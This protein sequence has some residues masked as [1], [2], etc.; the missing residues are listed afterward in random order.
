MWTLLNHVQRFIY[1]KFNPTATEQ[2][3]YDTQDTALHSMVLYSSLT[4]LPVSAT[5]YRLRP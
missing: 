3:L 5:N 4:S 2:L 1:H